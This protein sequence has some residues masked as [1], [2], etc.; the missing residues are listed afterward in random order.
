MSL[1]KEIYFNQSEDRFSIET[2]EP[3]RIGNLNSIAV[4]PV[5]YGAT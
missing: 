3:H 1:L 5:V 4:S 2:F